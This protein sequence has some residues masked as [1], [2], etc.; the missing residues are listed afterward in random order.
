MSDWKLLLDDMAQMFAGTMGLADGL[1]K[2]AEQKM[3]LRM[4]KM[5]KK[6]DFVS[7]QEFEVVAAMA[8]KARVEQ[9]RLQTELNAL[10]KS[11]V[12][13]ARPAKSA[14]SAKAAKKPARRKA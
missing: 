12:K 7:R 11:M 10:K 14:A 2:E 13:T 3:K 1:R 6:M 9:E 4:E 8:K 5:A